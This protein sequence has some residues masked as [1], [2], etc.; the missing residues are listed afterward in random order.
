MLPPV[1]LWISR[2]KLA[3]SF[4][5]VHSE[6]ACCWERNTQRKPGGRQK[7]GSLYFTREIVNWLGPIDPTDPRSTF[8][9]ETLIQ[10]S[11][12]RWKQHGFK[13]MGCPGL[14]RKNY[15]A[16]TTKCLCVCDALVEGSSKPPLKGE[17]Q[18][19]F[20]FLTTGKLF[21]SCV[22]TEWHKSNYVLG[23]TKNWDLRQATR[24]T[25]KTKEHPNRPGASPPC[26]KTQGRR[27][28]IG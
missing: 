15:A 3:C 22:A 13:R 12:L 1:D 2:G 18:H 28:R 25:A 9:G 24:P 23:F 6:D 8:G 16:R 5:E 19:P 11:R 26:E 14:G 17:T 7:E 20:V 4:V 21:I 27:R 10:C